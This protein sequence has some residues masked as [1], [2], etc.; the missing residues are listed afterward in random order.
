[1]YQQENSHTTPRTHELFEWGIKIW[2]KVYMQSKYTNMK[3]THNPKTDELFKWGIKIWSKVY[4]QSKCTNMKIHTQP[5]G[6]MS[7]LSGELR[8][9]QKCI[10][11][12]NVP[13][14]KFTHNPR[15]T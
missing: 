13:T 14:G 10:C 8:F 5:P 1:M 11:N 2:S 9:G 12:L 3:F 7:C 15:D 6:Y 4:M